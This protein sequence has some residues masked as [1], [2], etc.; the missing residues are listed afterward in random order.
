M[1]FLYALQVALKNI[2]SGFNFQCYIPVIN[3][4]LIKYACK[5]SWVNDGSVKKENIKGTL[6]CVIVLLVQLL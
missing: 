3:I 1:C 5:T 6:S 2:Y 4:L